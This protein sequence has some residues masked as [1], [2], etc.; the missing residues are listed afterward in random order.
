MHDLSSDPLQ[1]GLD[2]I[3]L[4]DVAG[5]GDHDLRLDRD[6]LE[7]LVSRG[8]EDRPHLHLD[9]LRHDDAEADAA[10]THHGVALVHAV[11]RL[12][13]FLVRCQSLAVAGHTLG[14]D[15]LEDLVVVGH[16]LVQRRVDEA[17]DDGQAIHRI[18][19]AC[20]VSALVRQQ[21][22]QRLGAAFGG[23]GEDHALHDGQALLLEEHVLG[24]AEANALG[25]EAASALCVSRVVSVGPDLKASNLVSPAQQGDEV[26]L[27]FELGE[28]CGDLAEVDLASRTVQGNPVPFRDGDVAHG[29]LALG[30]VDPDI[31]RTH[32]TRD[33]ELA[34]NH[35]GMAGGATLAGKNALGGQHAVHVVGA[36]EGAHHDDGLALFLGLLLGGISVEIDTAD[37]CAGGSV[38]AG[39]KQLAG[40]LGLILGIHGELGV[41]QRIHLAGL[42]AHDG[43]FAA[44]QPFVGHV[45]SDLDGSGGGALAIAGL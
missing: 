26:G 45:D 4:V 40:A 43:L 38:D 16:E 18:E 27:L 5:Q 2:D 42:N 33:T 11:D 36:G 9:D 14:D 1:L 6:A 32:D 20:K 34:G 35:G 37:G 44:D 23:L 22:I 7:R 15:A 29:H 24:A 17:H 13:Q 19:Q 31:G 41:Q 8:L 39:G 30:Q 21:F 12:E 10:H 3:E 28:D 25:A